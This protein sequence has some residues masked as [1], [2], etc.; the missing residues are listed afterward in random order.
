MSQEALRIGQLAKQVGISTSALRF[1][2]E[3]GL[4]GRPARTASGY[5]LYPRGAVG[6]L[7]FL[8]RAKALGLTLSEIRQLVE[9]PV[10]GAEEQRN[11][12]RH[13]VAHRL[14]ETQER[15]AELRALEVELNGLYLRLLRLPA[16]DCSHLGACACWLPTKE[17]VRAMTKEVAC[18][19]QL[20]CPACACAEG[21]PCDCA[22]CPCCVSAAVAPG[23]TTVAVLARSATAKRT[24]EL[25]TDAVTLVR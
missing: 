21:E 25:S 15:M 3:A 10:S 6:R 1:Y 13:V 4:L 9:A 18:C 23:V 14:A 22:E 17:E 20:C 8:L 7:Q 16:P 24:R 12:V 5:R 11:R 19:G 2:E